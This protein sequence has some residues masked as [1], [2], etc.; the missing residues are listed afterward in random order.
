[1]SIKMVRVDD[2]LIHGQIVAA[3]VK[4]LNLERVWLI[5]DGTANDN[6]LKNEVPN[7]FLGIYTLNNDAVDHHV[8]SVFCRIIRQYFDGFRTEDASLK[9]FEKSLHDENYRSY[10][11]SI[12]ARE[13]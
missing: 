11:L 4:S 2:G 5:D 12:M 8:F 10:V 9:P 13:T 1:M 6:F 3:W 7:T